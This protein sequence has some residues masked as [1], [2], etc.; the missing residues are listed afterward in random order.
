M[1]SSNQ[2][3]GILKYSGTSAQFES[4]NA[5]VLKVLEGEKKKTKTKGPYAHYT[6]S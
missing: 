1:S 3:Q 6:S 2:G 5:K 4:A